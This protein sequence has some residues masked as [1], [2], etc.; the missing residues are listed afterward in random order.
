MASLSSSSEEYKK[1]VNE[2]IKGK[3]KVKH[4]KESSTEIGE[5]TVLESKLVSYEEALSLL[6]LFAPQGQCQY[7]VVSS[8]SDE[9]ARVTVRPKVPSEEFDDGY[10]WR[11]YGR[12]YIF[13]PLLTRTYYRCI[14]HVREGCMAMK[15]VRMSTYEPNAVDIT[16]RGK[17]TCLRSA[18][19]PLEQV[20]G[21]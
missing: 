8:S 3:E 4:L 1:L 18:H 5:S 10:S 11:K 16:Y 13:A 21:I 14:D 6:K 12:E 9:S 15:E 7:N 2:I 19:V 17:H 20:L